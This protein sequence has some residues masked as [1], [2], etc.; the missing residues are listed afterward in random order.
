MTPTYPGH[1]GKKEIERRPLGR[2]GLSHERRPTRS[3]ISGPI[4]EA[5]RIRSATR[6][7]VIRRKSEALSGMS[8]VSVHS[9]GLNLISPTEDR[10][11]F[12]FSPAELQN[13][14]TNCTRRSCKRV[15]RTRARSGYV[16]TLKEIG[17]SLVQLRSPPIW[18]SSR[19]L[20]R[21]DV[22][23]D[24]FKA[25]PQI[26]AMQI[27]L[28]KAVDRVCCLYLKWSTTRQRQLWSAGP[29][30][31]LCLLARIKSRK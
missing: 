5:E 7:K 18:Q 4:M 12:F 22:P 27:I 9:H 30:G 23:P 10:R 1:T 16:T 20:L 11:D 28:Q 21:Q 19:T 15:T 2:S 13:P 14:S 3:H 17:D 8:S 6:K 25:N 24:F 31:R 29:L 26:S